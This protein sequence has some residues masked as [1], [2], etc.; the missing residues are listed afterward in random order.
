MG[1]T[2]RT[3]SGAACLIG[4]SVIACAGAPPLVDETDT[5]LPGRQ[6]QTSGDAA[7]ALGCTIL[8]L[9]ES[10][11]M[12]TTPA[13]GLGTAFAASVLV[14]GAAATCS[15]SIDGN[16]AA[17]EPC[18]IGPRA[19]SFKAEDVGG[20]GRH[21]VAIHVVGASGAADCSASVVVKPSCDVQ[22]LPPRARVGESFQY[23]IKAST[24][25]TCT[26]TVDRREP[27]AIGCDAAGAFPGS[28]FGVGAH[29]AVITAA[30]AG[31]TGTCTASFTVDP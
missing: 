12:D 17:P 1:A 22:I 20:L 30:G 15:V 7:P 24:G 31:Q 21:V 19:V 23:R 26:T 13:S 28:T 25:T 29:Q 5:P 16:E 2:R 9:P 6:A 14:E 11:A 27:A 10:G 4:S 8:L 3:L 18:Q